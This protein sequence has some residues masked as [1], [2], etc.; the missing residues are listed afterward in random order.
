ML[1]INII[2]IITLLAEPDTDFIEPEEN[3]TDEQIGEYHNIF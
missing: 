1:L 2:G 3:Y